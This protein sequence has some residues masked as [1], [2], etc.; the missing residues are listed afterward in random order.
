MS[1]YENRCSNVMS[2]CTKLDVY[3][4]KHRYHTFKMKA[5]SSHNA[6]HSTHLPVYY[7][8]MR[9]VTWCTKKQISCLGLPVFGKTVSICFQLKRKQIKLCTHKYFSVCVCTYGT[10]MLSWQTVILAA[11]QC[12]H[13]LTGYVH[14]T[15]CICNKNFQLTLL[16]RQNLVSRTRLTC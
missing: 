12:Y 13:Y 11:V 10:Q 4:A 8:H 14:H 5:E 16:R 15:V 1:V 9:Q 3:M 2:T 7:L 6:H